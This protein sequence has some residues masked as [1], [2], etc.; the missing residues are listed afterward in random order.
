MSSCSIFFCP[1][2]DAV[3]VGS[4]KISQ[5]TLGGALSLRLTQTHSTPFSYL[6]ARHDVLHAMLMGGADDRDNTRSA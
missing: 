6:V 5:R 2:L 3:H 1:L 4:F